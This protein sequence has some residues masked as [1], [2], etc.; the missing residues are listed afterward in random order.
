MQEQKSCAPLPTVFG[1][2]PHEPQ[3]V[4]PTS[5]MLG[6]EVQQHLEV[7][8][9]P[10]LWVTTPINI[11]GWLASEGYQIGEDC[12]NASHREMSS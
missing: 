6:V 5:G 8:R 9:L 4:P 11:A 10:I 1:L 12:C 2:Q 3:P 7:T